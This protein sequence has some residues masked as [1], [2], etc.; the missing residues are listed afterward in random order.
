MKVQKEDLT[1]LLQFVNLSLGAN[2]VQ[3]C[4]VL[5]TMLTFDPT[6]TINVYFESNLD[7]RCHQTSS[8]PHVSNNKNHNRNYPRDI[9]DGLISS[10]QAPTYL[11]L[12]QLLWQDPL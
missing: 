2:K 8:V 6:K 10:S 3:N 12:S 9:L 7:L 4:S 11:C 5:N 1:A